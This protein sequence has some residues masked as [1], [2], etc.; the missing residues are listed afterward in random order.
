[1]SKAK[2]NAAI[3]ALDMVETAWFW[4]SVLARPLKYL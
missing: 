3:A 1:M 4:A 2:M